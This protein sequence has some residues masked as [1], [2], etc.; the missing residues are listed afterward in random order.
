MA[1]QGKVIKNI[2][3]Q[4]QTI[5]DEEYQY[6]DDILTALQQDPETWKNFNGFTEP[7]KRI[8]VAY[9]ENA[10][11]RPEDFNKRLENLLKKTKANK[12]FGYE[13]SRF[14]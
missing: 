7:Y 11:T 5:L 12:K 4:V 8:R 9:V 14:Y 2:L 13:I 10:R 1:E 3:E 6:P